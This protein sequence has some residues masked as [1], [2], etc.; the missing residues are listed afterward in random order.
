MKTNVL[1][2]LIMVLFFTTNNLMSQMMLK[3]IS[4][5]EQVNNSS[6]VVEGK[7]ISKKSFW[8]VKHEK[9]YTTN[10]VEVY[11]VFKGVVVS[12]IEVI[13]VGG[14]VGDVI[15]M[16]F[17]NLNLR[18][19]DIGVFTLYDNNIALSQAAKAQN[20]QFKVYS[21]LQGFYKYNVYDDLAVNPFN[22]K[23]GIS[24]VFYKEIM[25]KTKVGFIEVSK[26]NVSEINKSLNQSKSSATP[27][28]SSFNPTTLSAGT[29]SQL[30]I[31]GSG[32]GSP[33]KVSF[34]DANAGGSTFIDALASQI[35]S[36]S[37]T[38][39]VVEVPSDAGTGKFRVTNN[40]SPTPLSKVSSTD[41]TISYSELNYEYDP[42]TGL[43]AYPLQH[44]DENGNGGYEWEMQTD[45]FNDSEHPGAK[46]AF[47]RAMDTWRCNTK[48]NWTISTTP[49]TT[50]VV[51]DDGINIVRFDN[52]NELDAGILGQCSTWPGGYTNCVTG[53]SVQFYVKELEIVFD[54]ATSW[55]FGTGDPG[56][57]FD[58]E[59]V[60]V[61]ELG[62]GHQLG[63]VI[64]TNAIMHFNLGLSEYNRV[65]S[66]NDINAGIDVQTR[67]TSTSVCG[68]LG[69]MTDYT[70]SCNLS[71][72]D[73]TLKDAVKM[74][75][76]P[77]NGTFYISNEFNV[78]VQKAVI[79]DIS[80][81]KIFEFDLSGTSKTKTIN[82]TGFSKGIY[83]INIH[84]NDAY[85]TKKIVL[86]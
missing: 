54:D 26:Y 46:V 28:I 24:S 45:F 32:F 5:D 17:P 30:T 77:T 35:V 4:L 81:R 64:D 12:T 1:I 58:F 27:V 18:V 3:Q 44:Y 75:P 62:H 63:H 80:G 13:T 11:K 38:K 2:T 34:P 47:E 70:G 73:E 25:S 8:D 69:S 39:I 42:G 65:L 31:N 19:G 15:L 72:E 37:D 66:S 20:K 51:L 23:E 22:K 56:L 36:W 67:S 33:G 86:E 61:H 49:T 16:V 7:V 55:Y 41:L 14:T 52:G 57:N 6:L 76:N 68:T 21:S 50:D 85:V 82:L 84:S 43:Q 29:K 40:D 60:A 74:Y 83:L 9:I 79:Y 78:N 71:V 59:S 10:T 48:I 53:A